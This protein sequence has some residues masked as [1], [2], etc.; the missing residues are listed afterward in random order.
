MADTLKSPSDESISYTEDFS[1][2]IQES[3]LDGAPEDAAVEAAL[4]AA[5]A[6]AA[7][8]KKKTSVFPLEPEEERVEEVETQ[9]VKLVIMSKMSYQTLAFI[10]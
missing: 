10:G 3:E 2:T 9:P 8:A 7:A 4:M 5:A 1:V 6:A